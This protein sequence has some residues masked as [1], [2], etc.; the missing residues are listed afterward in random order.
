MGL[1]AFVRCRCLEEGRVSEPPL[2]MEDPYVDGEGCVSSRTLDA[3]RE[4]LGR[5]E[6]SRCFW[7][8]QDRLAQWS[9]SCCEHED[10][11][12]RDEW[13]CNVSGW[14]DLRRLF[15][16]LGERG[17]PSSRACC[18][19]ATAAPSR[20]SWQSGPLA[21]LDILEKEVPA[22]M[23]GRFARLVRCSNG[24]SCW[25]HRDEDGYDW[26]HAK[27][28]LVG[29]RLLVWRDGCP[30]RDEA[31]FA[32]ARF[33]ATLVEGRIDPYHNMK[34]KGAVLLED[35]DGDAAPLRLE[36]RDFR[37]IDQFFFEGFEEYRVEEG[38]DGEWARW[39]IGII[40]RL[41]TASRDT[42]NPIQWC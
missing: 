7:G 27:S 3:E 31:D 35:L 36:W 17:R 13:A 39:K 41:F 11:H 14:S 9:E 16:A 25:A 32:S 28:R 10:M 8:L 38:A 6:F 4:R 12:A 18:P 33:R 30:G 1:D 23:P 24:I 21:E 5:R 19:A 22:L 42:G 20:Q 34:R 2:P 15:G 40:R 29:G 26:R 37:Q